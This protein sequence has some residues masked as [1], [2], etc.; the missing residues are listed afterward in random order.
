MGVNSSI[1]AVHIINFEM[2]ESVARCDIYLRVAKRSA[3][4]QILTKVIFAMDYYGG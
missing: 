4:L 3:E 1:P 2:L